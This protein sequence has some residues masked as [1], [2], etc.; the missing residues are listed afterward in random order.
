MNRKQRRAISRKPGVVFCEVPRGSPL[1]DGEEFTV[2]GAQL[3]PGEGW[4]ADCKP[5]NET[6]MTAVVCEKPGTLRI[7]AK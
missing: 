2:A 4:I 5:G 3:I 1:K 6:V 7:I